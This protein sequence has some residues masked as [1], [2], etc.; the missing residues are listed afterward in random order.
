ML[1]FTAIEQFHE[2]AALIPQA[3]LA[4]EMTNIYRGIYLTEGRL[5]YPNISSGHG[6][7]PEAISALDNG[8]FMFQHLY[9]QEQCQ[10]I[11]RLFLP[12]VDTILSTRFAYTRR[13]VALVRTN[14]S[15]Y[16]SVELEQAIL[17]LATEL[18]NSLANVAE[19]EIKLKNPRGKKLR[20]LY[21]Y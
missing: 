15:S 2:L 10:L 19:P 17:P 11:I 8:I 1:R 5:G 7:I 16:S 9:T 14:L 21:L 12:E 3:A 6:S 4:N 13:L 18:L 20:Y